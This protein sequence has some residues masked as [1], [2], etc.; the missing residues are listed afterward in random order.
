MFSQAYLT[1]MPYVVNIYINIGV[2]NYP[3]APCMPK[4]CMGDTQSKPS[5][6]LPGKQH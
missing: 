6:L 2:K 4:N 5:P 1:R 3:I